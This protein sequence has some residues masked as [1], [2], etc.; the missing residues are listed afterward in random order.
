MIRELIMSTQLEVAMASFLCKTMK[1]QQISELHQ[2]RTCEIYLL[3]VAPFR[4]L[5]QRVPQ[6]SKI[7]SKPSI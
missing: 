7:S 6:G 3:Q 4:H 2:R 5:M 1:S